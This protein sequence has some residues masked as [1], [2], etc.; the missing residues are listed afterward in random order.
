MVPKALSIVILALV[1]IGCAGSGPA[2]DENGPAGVL[3]TIVSPRRPVSANCERN[4]LPPAFK[5][6]VAAIFPGVAGMVQIE[7]MVLVEAKVGRGGR[8]LSAEV[9]QSVHPLL[10][11]AAVDATN[12]CLFWPA[13]T[14]CEPVESV[15]RVGFYFEP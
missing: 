13:V 14:D 15:I 5:K 3:P 4:P 10:I 12:D 2:G 7:G 1:L 11:K 6:V 8:V 9:V